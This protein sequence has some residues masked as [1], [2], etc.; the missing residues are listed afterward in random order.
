MVHPYRGQ[1]R[2]NKEEDV[3]RYATTLKNLQRTTV[4]KKANPQK[5]PLYDSIYLT[6]LKGQVVKVENRLVVPGVK[7]EMEAGG[8]RVWL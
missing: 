6:F 1:P 3:L 7:V 5:L 8:K 4:S 2:N